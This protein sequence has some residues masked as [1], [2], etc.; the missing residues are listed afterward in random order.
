ML[1]IFEK[2]VTHD[3]LDHEHRRANHCDKSR[4]QFNRI[5]RTFNRHTMDQPQRKKRSVTLIR[6]NLKNKGDLEIEF[7]ELGQNIGETQSQF[8]NYC[9]VMVRTRISIL[10]LCWDEVPKA[11]IDELWLNTKKHWNIEDDRHKKQVLKICNQS[12]KAYKSR[13]VNDYLKK[14]RNLVPEYPYLDEPT[15]NAFVQLK[16]SPSFQE[17]SNKATTTAKLNKYPP[18]IGPRGYR[19]MKHQWEKEMESGESTEFHNIRSERARNFILARL[20]RDPTGIYSLPTDLYSLASELIEKDTQLSH[21][22]WFPGP[23][24]DVLTEVLGPEH[25]GRTRAVG[26]NVGLRQSMPRVDKKKGKSHDKYNLED[27]KEKMKIEVEV[28]AMMEAKMEAKIEEMNAQME[29]MKTYMQQFLS[30]NEGIHITSPLLKKNSVVSTTPTA[31]ELVI[32]YDAMNQ[33]CA[34]GMVF[35]YGN[36]Q[37]HSVPL[38]ANHLRVSIDKIYDQYDCIPLPV[39]TEEASK[40]CEALHGIVEWPRNAIKIIQSSQFKPNVEQDKRCSFLP[41]AVDPQPRITKSVP[42]ISKGVMKK[43]KPAKE[44]LIPHNSNK[45]VDL[46]KMPLLM[47]RI[48][49]RLMNRDAPDDA[50]YVEAE[51]GI[52]GAQKIETYI[53]PE[54][55]LRL[56]NKQWL[57]ISVITWFQIML[58]SML[59]TRGGNKVNRCAFI[60]PSEIQATICESNGEDVM[61]LVICP[62]QGTGYIL[63]SQK[64]PDEKP[65]ENYI[66]VKYV[67][68]AVARLKEAIDTTHPMKWTLVECNQQPS[69]WECGFYVMRWMFEFVLTQQN[70]F[71]NKNNWNDK[72]PFPDWVLNEIIVMWSSR[73]EIVDAVRNFDVVENLVATGNFAAVGIQA[74]YDIVVVAGSYSENSVDSL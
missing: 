73:F 9:G 12:W 33:K 59:E 55:I 36:G 22:D 4:E 38:N 28:E 50:I 48:Y 68:E 32:P 29:E 18:R 56:L 35:P 67:E 42:V 51:P 31:C 13:L 49:R 62:N 61:L 65:V 21:G 11:E 8:S 14:G 26:H 57:D 66:V 30:K 53:Y 34:K 54:E 37:I 64:N 70:E 15:W 46:E 71:P 3:P 43:T 63:N 5:V 25:P 69:S 20:K 7:D 41:V 24:A 44:S 16:T 52:L 39:S 74:D 72:K 58:H 45:Q 60:S 40:M 1:L 6:G 23:G 27:I 2:S 47:K 10:I 17:I 19:G